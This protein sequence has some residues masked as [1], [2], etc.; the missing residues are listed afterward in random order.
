L[1][2]H[3]R[4]LRLEARLAGRGLLAQEIRMDFRFDGA[5]PLSRELRLAE[6]LRDADTFV[7]LL[8]DF[9]DGMEWDSPLTCL[10]IQIPRTVPAREGQ[11]SLF[12]DHLTQFADLGQYVS[13]LRARYG[14][15]SVGFT[16]LESSYLPERSFRVS[17]PPLAPDLP[18][19]HFPERPLF[20]FDPPR[21]YTPSRQGRLQP[22]ENL[23]AEWWRGEGERRY[24]IH[25]TPQGVRL[26]VY[27]DMARRQWFLHGTFD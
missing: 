7:R 13:R 9:L 21:L 10:R 16:K 27:W 17:W 2:A 24:F 6:P 25:H 8:R 22:T 12:D 18:K 19:S 3:Q 11:L 26:W 15:T 20:V 4:W 14:E 1:V 5:P 23:A